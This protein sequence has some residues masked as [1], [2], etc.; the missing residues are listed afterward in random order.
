MLR[1]RQAKITAPA[2]AGCTVSKSH[3][4]SERGPAKLQASLMCGQMSV[5]ALDASTDVLRQEQHN[6][7]HVTSPG[8]VFA[9]G[10]HLQYWLFCLKAK[11]QGSQATFQV[12]AQ[13]QQDRFTSK[14]LPWLALRHCFQ[15]FRVR[16]RIRSLRLQWG[17][18]S[19]AA[20][21]QQALEQVTP[22]ELVSSHAEQ[23]LA[24]LSGLEQPF[25]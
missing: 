24:E 8:F 9:A 21:G 14:A 6:L 12:T 23:R 17:C 3:S 19:N 15:K 2:S 20:C 1:I 13:Q 22:L 16:Y 5:D 10:A 25:P 4:N 7:Q 11:S 18:I